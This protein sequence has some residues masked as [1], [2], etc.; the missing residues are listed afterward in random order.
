MAS[1]TRSARLNLA[2]SHPALRTV[3]PWKALLDGCFEGRWPET[4]IWSGFSADRA[5]RTASGAAL[6]FVAPSNPPPSA[7]AFEEKIHATGEVETRNTTWHD[8]F[9]ALAWLMFP[10]TKARINAVHVADGL[11]DANEAPN[12]RSALRNRL[13]LFDE[14]GLIVA[15]CNSALHNLVRDFA[16]QR[17]FWQER[18]AVQTQMDFVVFGHALYERALNLHYGS[19][20]RAWLVPVPPAY[21][22]WD[23][24]CRLAFLDEYLSTA[25]QDAPTAETQ[26]AL[27]QAL[28]V[29]GIPGWA[30]ENEVEAY[31]A[32]EKQFRPKRKIA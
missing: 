2:L 25:L 28:P 15:S 10:K 8:T 26:L 21:F 16:W 9:H 11:R 4:S 27:L 5:L 29:K 19:T 12:R 17:L 7:L 23:D 18:A 6:R 1:A 3:A 22:E 32:D 14:G 13:T 24:A 30:A 20:G 31:Y